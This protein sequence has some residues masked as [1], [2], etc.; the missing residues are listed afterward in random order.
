MKKGQVPL[1]RALSKLGLASRTEARALVREG[2]VAVDGRPVTDP[3]F[4]VVPERVRIEID[5]H[6]AEKPRPMTVLLHKPRGVVTT[7][8][9]PDG[10]PTV[11]ACLEGLDAHVV[12]VGRLDAATS[13]LLLLTNDTRFADW[14]TDPTNEVPRV[15][16]VTVRGELTDEQARERE[17]L[18]AGSVTV[19]KRSKRETHLVIEL[20]EGKNREIRRMLAAIGH[21]VTKLKRVS[22]GGLELGE[23][24]AGKWREVTTE[25]LQGAFP[26]ADFPERLGEF[27]ERL[28]EI[29]E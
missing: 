11:Y 14:I 1:E 9:D 21:E 4:E 24:P 15:Y 3:L 5:G 13:G 7:R 22:F 23:L 18:V 26:G 16:L 6:P 28:R 8:S 20:T 17:R 27:P 19:R 29:P 10:R 12:P 2:R 25:E